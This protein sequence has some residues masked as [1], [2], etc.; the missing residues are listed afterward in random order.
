MII[1]KAEQEGG[2]KH[3]I[4]FLGRYCHAVV[5]SLLDAGAH[6]SVSV[7]APAGVRQEG[8]QHRSFFLFFIC[9]SSPPS[10]CRLAFISYPEKG[11]AFS[12]PRR[13]LRR[14]LCAHDIADLHC[15]VLCD[16][17]P[18]SLQDSNPR[19]KRRRVSR[20]PNR[21]TG[22]TGAMHSENIMS[23]QILGVSPEGVGTARPLGRD[24]WSM[25]E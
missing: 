8:G 4:S 15:R 1:T 13:P 24:A 5:P 17:Y 7:G 23:A 2:I 18:R 20:L 16:K 25:I 9:F 21:A 14:I 10:F 6:P 19:L 12:S 3:E 22:A 11:S